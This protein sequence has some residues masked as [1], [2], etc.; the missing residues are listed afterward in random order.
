[1]AKILLLFLLCALTR[2]SRQDDTNPACHG[3]DGSIY[4]PEC[5]TPPVELTREELFKNGHMKRFGAHRPPDFIVEELPYMIA[6]EDFHALYVSKH[7][8]VVIKGAAKYWPA[9]TKWTDEYLLQKWGD[10]TFNMETKDDD[11]VNLPPSKKLKD[12]LKVYQERDLYLVDEVHPEMREDV[13]LPLCLRC[14][15][16]C[17]KFFVSYY[18]HSSGNTSSTLHIDTD[19]NLLCV[20]RGS[21]KAIL[22]SPVY[23]N[24]LYADDANLL[25]VSPVPADKVD[26]EKFPRVM[27]VHYQQANMEEGDCLYLPQMWWHQVD[28]GGG[29]QQA[30]A[31][32][33]KSKPWWKKHGKHA[34]PVEAETVFEGSRSERKYSFGNALALY[35]T[36]VNEVAPMTPRLKCESQQTRMSEFH[37][38]T[39]HGDTWGADVGQTHGSE[40]DES[41]RLDELCDFDRTNPLNPCPVCMDDEARHHCIR[42]ILDYCQVYQD[43]GCVVQ[44]PQLLNKQTKEDFESIATMESPFHT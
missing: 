23:S 44:L 18:W 13:I 38:E 34:P 22:V 26:L 41:E 43:R 1:M 7:K 6:P 8:P 16:M 30:V 12:F 27:N 42:Y 5:N 15:E 10:V 14:E 21:K 3:A 17:T 37:F 36:W 4:S 28:S 24:D 9:Y 2:I 31:L 29:R 20:I 25:G 40:E 19:E 35:E 39:D 11:K 33:W 32:W